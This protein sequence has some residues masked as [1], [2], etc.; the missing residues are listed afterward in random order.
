[1]LHLPNEMANSHRHDTAPSLLLYGKLQPGISIELVLFAS[2]PTSRRHG[3]QMS[4][5]D[6][7]DKY[8]SWKHYE[9][10]LNSLKVFIR[11]GDDLDEDLPTIIHHS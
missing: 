4:L 9:T 7:C 5:V 2:V 1:M 3:Y 8:L 10:G 11:N 6:P